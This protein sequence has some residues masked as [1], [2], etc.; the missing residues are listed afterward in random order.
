[1][2][3][4]QVCPRYHPYI[5][6]IETHVKEISER[7]V[8]RGFETEVLSCD[9]SGKLSR[10]EIVNG[11]RVR[12][13][14]SWAPNEA[15]Y[16][17]E[18]LRK[19]LMKN[20]E[21]FD[22]VHAHSYHAL[23]AFYAAQ[24]KVRNK[25]VFTPHYHGKG[26]TFFRSLLHTPYKYLGKR[27]F[28]KAEKIVC[29]SYYEKSLIVKNFGVREEKVVVIPNG[30]NWTEFGNLEKRKKGHRAILFVGR[31]EEYKGVQYLIEVLPMLDCDIVLEIVGDGPYKESLVRLARKLKVENRVRF[32]KNLSRAELLQKYVD[33]DI[34]VML[35]KHEA[36]GI[37]VTEALCAGTPCIVA[38]ASALTEWVD[39]KH[40]FGIEC[41]ID[42][43]ELVNL[44]NKVIDIRIK[45]VELPDWNDVTRDLE[46]V[47][48]SL[49]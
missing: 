22:I 47:Y 7:L 1:M 43:D 37:S 27:I 36:Y 18:E 48:D 30:V 44:L 31:L 42:R 19:Y 49:I 4:A 8:E 40:C 26:H 2:K 28:E 39:G 6:G 32:F 25:L 13:F 46:A 38:K 41:P 16:F 24:A 10:N 35:S 11:I 45:G 33:T 17:S 21:S 23:P 29:V 20:S 5:G 14:R 12:R 15:Y 9:P 34:F 3:I